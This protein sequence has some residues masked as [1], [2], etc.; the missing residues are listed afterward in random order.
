MD[1]KPALCPNGVIWRTTNQVRLSRR[2]KELTYF[3][4]LATKSTDVFLN[5]GNGRELIV[6]PEVPGTELVCLRSLREPQRAHTVVETDVDDGCSPNLTISLST[7]LSEVAWKTYPQNALHDD[8]AGVEDRGDPFQVAH[9]GHGSLQRE[10]Q[11]GWAEDIHRQTI[12]LRNA[13][14]SRPTCM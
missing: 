2:R 13:R 3:I 10:H 6:E 7:S 9:H 4:R 8:L 12:R 14:A 5:L 11:L 1:I